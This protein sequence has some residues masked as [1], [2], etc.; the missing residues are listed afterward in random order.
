[1]RQTK[2]VLIALVVIALLLAIAKFRQPIVNQE[3]IRSGDQTTI[4]PTIP[5]AFVTPDA[6]TQ[7]SEPKFVMLEIDSQDLSVE[8]ARTEEEITQGLSNRTLLGSD[9]M[10][11]VIDPPRVPSFWMKGMNFP[12]DIIWIRNGKIVKIDH[13]VPAPRIDQNSSSLPTYQPPSAVDHVLE[14]PAGV[15]ATYGFNVGNSF[16]VTSNY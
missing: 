13:D 5:V 10:L 14:L 6:D 16:S 7:N 9:G 1:M 4:Q 3:N 12:L 8:V 15:A 2:G 11:F